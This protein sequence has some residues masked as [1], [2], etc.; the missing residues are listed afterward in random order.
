MLQ[1]VERIVIDTSKLYGRKKKEEKVSRTNLKK[2]GMV[3]YK[4]KSSKEIKH[5]IKFGSRQEY[6]ENIVVFYI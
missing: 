2:P 5:S 1:K 3:Q 6:L 4:R